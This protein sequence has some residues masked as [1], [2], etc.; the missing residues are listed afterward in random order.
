MEPLTPG[1]TCKSSLL[2]YTWEDIDLLQPVHFT[3]GKTE[4]PTLGVGHQPSREHNLHKETNVE[5]ASMLVFWFSSTFISV[6]SQWVSPG[7]MPGTG[8]GVAGGPSRQTRVSLG[9]VA[10]METQPPNR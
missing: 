8:W 7:T 5:L 3:D 4:A 6:V 10:V 1:A 9:L 2:G